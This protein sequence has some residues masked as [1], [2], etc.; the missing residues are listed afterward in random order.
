MASFPIETNLTTI[1]LYTESNY[2]LLITAFVEHNTQVIMIKTMTFNASMETVTTQPSDGCARL[3]RCTL[4]LFSRILLYNLVKSTLQAHHGIPAAE[5][6]SF[7]VFA[8][9]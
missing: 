6:H 1:Q 5:T 4:E 8:P 2:S 7:V 3:A 9:L